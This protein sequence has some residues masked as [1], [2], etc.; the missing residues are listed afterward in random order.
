MV[1]FLGTALLCVALVVV[2]L[3]GQ[4]R[5]LVLAG[6]ALFLLGVFGVTVLA[7][8]PLND[9][10][11]ESDLAWTDYLRR[12]TAWNTVRSVASL[13]AAGALLIV[14]LTDAG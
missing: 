3:A 6:A 11:A 7:N 10:L 14:V 4:R 9:A 5:P 8:V 13:A 1:L 2:E 12:W